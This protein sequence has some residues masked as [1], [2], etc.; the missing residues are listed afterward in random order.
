MI[1][2]LAAGQAEPLTLTTPNAAVGAAGLMSLLKGLSVYLLAIGGNASGTAMKKYS[3]CLFVHASA[4]K[5][6]M[7]SFVS[8]SLS[9]CSRC[10]RVLVWDCSFWK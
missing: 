8:T 2:L 6:A 3:G 5:E 1:P 10:G 4:I 9:F 7:I